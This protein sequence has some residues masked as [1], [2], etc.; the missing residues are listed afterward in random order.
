MRKE[1][2]ETWIEIRNLHSCHAIYG[3]LSWSAPKGPMFRGR[4]W[5][6]DQRGLDCLIWE[7]PEIAT[8]FG[9]QERTEGKTPDAG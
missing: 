4:W 2:D 6:F 9:I 5:E 7:Q 8:H 1:P 3:N